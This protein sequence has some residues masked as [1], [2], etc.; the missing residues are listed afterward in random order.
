MGKLRFRQVHL[1]FH[2]SEKIEGVGDD[3]DPKVFAETLK[4][5]GVDSI[6]CFAR[7]HHGMIYYD[8]DA[9]PNKHPHLKRNLLKEQIEACHAVGIKV[10][11]YITVGWD[12]Y[13]ARTHPEWLE[14][15]TEGKPY[16][17]GPLQ[18][19]WKT[20]CFNTPYVDHVEKQTIDVLEKF[21]SDVDGLFF[22]IIFQNPC[23]CTYC[24]EGM[25]QEGFDPEVE[26]DRQKYA[27]KVVNQFKE[28]ITN[29][30]RNITR[31]APSFIMQDI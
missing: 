30:V 16:W 2:T 29:A 1:D 18:A 10:P 22:D 23:C 31:T 5:A 19:G 3:F 26:A 20:F 11:I 17:A 8:T 6:T 25:E 27:D 12:E 15:T 4:E 14:R 24:M 13:I 21:G 28:R 7:C 9:F